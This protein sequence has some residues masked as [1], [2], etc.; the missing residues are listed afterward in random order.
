MNKLLETII[1]SVNQGLKIEFY[2]EN[3]Y[4]NDLVTV[5]VTDNID[6]KSSEQ[7]YNINDLELELIKQISKVSEKT[8]NLRKRQNNS[9]RYI[10]Q[11]DSCS[12]LEY[13]DNIKYFMGQPLCRKC[14]VPLY[15]KYNIEFKSNTEPIPTLNEYKEQVKREERHNG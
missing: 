12:R 7:E 13:A 1:N 11:C 15:K 6:I 5:K 3:K 10:V 9:N 8:I 14:Y 4:Y 2:K